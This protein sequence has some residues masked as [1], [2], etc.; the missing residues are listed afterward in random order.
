MHRKQF[1]RNFS[2]SEKEIFINCYLYILILEREKE[3]AYLDLKDNYY[4]TR[5]NT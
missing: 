3:M 4:V 5:I 1:P 2:Q